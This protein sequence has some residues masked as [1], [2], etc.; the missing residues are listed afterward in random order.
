MLDE[1]ST[2][3]T[4][5]GFAIIRELSEIELVIHILH[6]RRNA[7]IA[8]SVP[9]ILDVRLCRGGVELFVKVRQGGVDPRPW[10]GRGLKTV[11]LCELVPQPCTKNAEFRGIPSNVIV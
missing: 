7:Q 1:W 6:A 3:Q 9:F 2:V 5:D 4:S 10:V 8:E 11:S